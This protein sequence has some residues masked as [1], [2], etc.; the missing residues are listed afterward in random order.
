MVCPNFSWYYVLKS[1]ESDREMRE[2]KKSALHFRLRGFFRERKVTLGI[3]L[4]TFGGAAI[5]ACQAAFLVL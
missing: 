4:A 1:S 5:G 2:N 3:R